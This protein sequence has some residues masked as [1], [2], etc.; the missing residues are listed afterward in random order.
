MV[1]ALGFARFTPHAATRRAL[2][3]DATATKRKRER[4]RESRAARRELQA[5]VPPLLP[6]KYTPY[7]HTYVCR[8]SKSCT[9]GVVSAVSRVVSRNLETVSSTAGARLGLARFQACASVRR[10]RPLSSPCVR[11]GGPPSLA[12]ARERASSSRHWERRGGALG[13][14]AWQSRP[15]PRDG[16]T[17]YAAASPPSCHPTQLRPAAL[18]LLP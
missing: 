11:G 17:R 5:E 2:F 15:R 3:Q 8:V 6:S 10:S 9:G 7:L 4:E 14:T 16:A 13:A 12:L 1:G 18:L